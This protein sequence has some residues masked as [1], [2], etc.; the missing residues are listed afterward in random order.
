MKQP[1]ISTLRPR[2]Q[3]LSEDQ[4]WAIH[5]AALEIL[6]TTGFTMEHPQVQRSCWTPAADWTAT[7]AP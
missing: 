1:N 2:M 6:E 3:V 7:A 5:H 4:A